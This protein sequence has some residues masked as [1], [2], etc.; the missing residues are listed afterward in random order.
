MRNSSF[1]IF[2]IRTVVAVVCCLSSLLACQESTSPSQQT[3]EEVATDSLLIDIEDPLVLLPSLT[4]QIEKNPRNYALYEERSQVYYELDK[5]PEAISDIDKAIDLYDQR[6]E[7]HY[8]RGFYAF[9]QNDTALALTEHRKSI[10]LGSDNPENFYQIGQIFFLQKRYPAALKHYQFAALQDTLQP[11]YLFAQG[12]LHQTRKQ[13]GKAIRAYEQSVGL[14]SAFD[15]SLIALHNLQLDVY[16]NPEAS[17]P[18]LDQLIAFNP[19]HALA[20]LYKGNYHFNRALKVSDESQVALF[21]EEINAA[22]LEYSI[23]VQRDT[24][25]AQAWYN[26]GYCYFLADDKYDQAIADFEQALVIRPDYPEANY[27]LGSIY[28]RFE[29]KVAALRYYQAALEANPEF[30]A[31][32]TAVRELTAQ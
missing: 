23:A 26:R 6:S 1:C 19:G 11:I 4:D 3:K 29:D 30:T 15:K 22:V 16:Q 27:M 2:P 9:V 18:Y 24:R 8:L 7:L 13:Y 25:M 32:A 31:A 17:V 12:I 5:L 14:D 20:R 28:E 21:Q 10:E